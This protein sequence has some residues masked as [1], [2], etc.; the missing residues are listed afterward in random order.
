MFNSRFHRKPAVAP[1]PEHL[2]T[3]PALCCNN[4]M[5]YRTYQRP[6]PS[7]AATPLL[8]SL[9]QRVNTKVASPSLPRGPAAAGGAGGVGT[10]P[11][12]SQ[13]LNHVQRQSSLQAAGSTSAEE[14]QQIVGSEPERLQSLY[15]AERGMP[16]N[17][18]A[19]IA[20]RTLQNALSNGKAIAHWLLSTIVWGP[21]RLGLAIFRSA[22]VLVRCRGLSSDEV[23]SSNSCS[24]LICLQ[25]LFC[26]DVAYVHLCPQ[27]SPADLSLYPIVCTGAQQGRQSHCSRCR[28]AAAAAAGGA[29][30]GAAHQDGPKGTALP[31]VQ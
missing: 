3:V 20:R 5:T 30:P 12:V 25:R 18:P 4:M 13:S 31:P 23:S 7:F 6:T 8:E 19:I 21:F 1:L 2:F 16:H 14:S 27:I 10:A 17:S 28:P 9:S 11:G 29:I 26:F 22:C 24:A 15:K